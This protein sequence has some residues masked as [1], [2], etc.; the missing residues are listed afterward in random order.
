MDPTLGM[1]P[2]HLHMY[3]HHPHAHVC[4]HVL[5]HMFMCTHSCTATHCLPPP[6]PLKTVS[7]N[8]GMDCPPRAG[9]TEGLHAAAAAAATTVIPLAANSKLPHH[10]RVA[11]R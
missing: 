10:Q 8:W 2:A 4:M 6:A 7:Q 1:H 3:G 9:L 5:L 11:A